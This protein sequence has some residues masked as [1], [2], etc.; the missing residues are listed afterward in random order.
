MP[1][2][3]G[4]LDTARALIRADTSPGRG[5]RTA[6]SLLTPLYEA[7]GLAARPQEDEPGE[8]GRASCRER[9]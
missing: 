4:F 2:P 8:I 7:A 1:L 9:V 5:T 6:A 3:A